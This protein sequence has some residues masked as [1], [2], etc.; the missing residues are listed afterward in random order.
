M[1]LIGRVSSVF[2][3]QFAVV[4]RIWYLLYRIISNICCLFFCVILI[5][6]SS[7]Y[8]EYGTET[9][10][11]PYTSIRQE[12]PTVSLCFDLSSLLFQNVT[13]KYFYSNYP[14]YVSLRTNSIFK[15]SPP[16]TQLLR[17][18]SYRLF[19]IDTFWSNTNSTECTILFNITRYIMQ[20]YICYKLQFAPTEYSFY[21]NTNSVFER[22]KLFKFDLK[23]PFD[24][25]HTILPILHFN[26]LRKTL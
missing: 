5:H 25:G 16:V 10:A 9:N 8:F 2:R 1:R 4:K 6:V 26:R 22:R 18:R 20:K 15:K 7:R 23:R 24:K 17:S 19:K 21:L 13:S 12:L 11:A 3:M 14:S